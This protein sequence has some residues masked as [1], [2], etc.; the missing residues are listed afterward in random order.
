MVAGSGHS[1]I[2]SFPKI[3]HRSAQHFS[4]R[5]PAPQIRIRSVLGVHCASH[6]H[7]AGSPS[8]HLQNG[9]G[10]RSRCRG[11]SGITGLR[12]DGIAGGGW[13]DNAQYCGR[14]YERRDHDDWGEGGRYD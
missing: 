12:R 3:R 5:M 1:R 4:A 2:A 7:Y 14:T 9:P 8:G 6:S 11:G 13:V 10:D